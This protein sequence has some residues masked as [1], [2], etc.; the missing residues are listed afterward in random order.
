[1]LGQAGASVEDQIAG[2]VEADLAPATE[3]Q[4]VRVADVTHHRFGL[5]GIQAARLEA[6]QTQDHRPVGGVAATGQ[7]QGGIQGD[8]HPLRAVQFAGCPE[9]GQESARRRHGTHGMGTGGTDSHFEQVE[10]ADVHERPWSP[11][12]GS[13][14]FPHIAIRPL[15]A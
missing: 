13:R 3:R 11:C 7:G 5:V 1:M 9:P 6:G 4:T 15:K 14:E 10:D 8:L 2:L 12:I